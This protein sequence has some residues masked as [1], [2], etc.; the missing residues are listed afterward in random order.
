VDGETTAIN[1]HKIAKY[2]K[3]EVS[4]YSCRRKLHRT[5]S[6][7]RLHSKKIIRSA[8]EKE[9]KDLFTSRLKIKEEREKHFGSVITCYKK[10]NI[11]DNA[12]CEANRGGECSDMDQVAPFNPALALAAE[13]RRKTRSVSQF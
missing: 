10:H 9:N 3:D 12:R 6:E 5:I 7:Q 4:K 8:C 1:L 11:E 13:K 2:G